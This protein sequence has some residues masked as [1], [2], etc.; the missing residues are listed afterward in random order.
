MVAK[1]AGTNKSSSK[2]TIKR[3][4]TSPASKKLGGAK[5]AIP[6]KGST[7]KKKSPA[8]VK[9]SKAK[10]AKPKSTA[11]KPAGALKRTAKPAPKAPIK[12][13]SKTQAAAAKPA[14]KKSAATINKLVEKKSSEKVLSTVTP[15][16][17]APSQ[18]T[19]TAQ[20]MLSYGV[21]A[22]VIKSGEAYM[23]DA[24]L[25][26]FRKLLN[27]WKHAL[28]QGGDE[29]LSHLKESGEVSA[30]ISDQATQE[31]NFALKLRTRDRERKLIKKIEESIQ[32]IDN[33][34]YGFCEE[35]GVEIGVRRL[36][37]RP[38]ATLCI[39]CKT[40]DEVREKQGR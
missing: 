25:I 13:A 2:G 32:K 23:S 8:E 35:C 37:A 22:Y 17:Q 9:A 20:T 1:A 5:K 39:D 38:T 14:T 29:T 40:L 26:H 11:A 30:D 19:S 28:L 24:Q 3:G 15:E 36:E 10:T 31:E 34:E 18:T 6:P 7:V 4:G 27:V 33:K 12:A 21:E 16:I